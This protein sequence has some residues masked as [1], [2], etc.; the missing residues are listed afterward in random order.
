MKRNFL[1]ASVAVMAMVS[2]GVGT[3]S[4][5]G[6]TSVPYPVNT[7]IGSFQTFPD[8]FGYWYAGNNDVT[9]GRAGVS[10]WIETP[11]QVSWANTSITSNTAGFTWT[12]DV[13]G[14]VGQPVGDVGGYSQ[15]SNITRN[16]VS[17]F[18]S[19][20]NDYPPYP[21]NGNNLEV[22]NGGFSMSPAVLD[23]GTFR[24]NEWLNSYDGFNY[25]DATISVTGHMIDSTLQVPTTSISVPSS[26]PEP[27]S[28]SLMGAGIAGL[29]LRRKRR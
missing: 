14:I 17:S 11:D 8:G 3:A 10:G 7:N 2:L 28:L 22:I 23:S 12:L 27:A 24:Y 13:S 20:S 25:Y 26:V 29:L 9:Q 21:V 15:Y 4:A 19:I 6:G 1:M 16:G 5:A 18:L